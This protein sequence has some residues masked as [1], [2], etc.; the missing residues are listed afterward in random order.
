MMTDSDLLRKI[1]ED[2]GLKLSKVA[3][4][5]GISDPALNRKINNK[6]S[7]M[8]QEILKLCDLLQIKSLK[9]KEDI[10]FARM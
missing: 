3:S 6:S 1:I 8:A 7:F 5:L 10:F 4:T 2:R 9:L